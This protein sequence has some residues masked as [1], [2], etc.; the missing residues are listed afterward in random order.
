VAEAT[1]TC[2]MCSAGRSYLRGEI[3]AVCV[4]LKCFTLRSE[5]GAL[6]YYW[7]LVNYT[8][9]LNA[10]ISAVAKLTKPFISQSLVGVC[11]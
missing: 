4:E 5:Q 6:H 7:L 11:C 3:S 1:E 2:L 8:R 10:R 9:T